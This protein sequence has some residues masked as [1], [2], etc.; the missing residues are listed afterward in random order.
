[1]ASI[2]EREQ[3]HGD[4]ET[5]GVLDLKGVRLVDTIRDDSCHEERLQAHRSRDQNRVLVP[6]VKEKGPTP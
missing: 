3:K 5:L 1:M 6:L 4:W 2:R